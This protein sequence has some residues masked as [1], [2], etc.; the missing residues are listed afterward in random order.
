MDGSGKLIYNSTLRSGTAKTFS[1]KLLDGGGHKRMT[2]KII[3]NKIF[4]KI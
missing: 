1:G 3:I 4:I 2:S